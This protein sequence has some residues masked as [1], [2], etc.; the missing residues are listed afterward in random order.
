MGD[1]DSMDLSPQFS[2]ASQL[3]INDEI[4]FLSNQLHV[5]GNISS[6]G[7]RF[8]S[9]A[10]AGNDRRQVIGFAPSISF[11]QVS[12]ALKLQLVLSKIV[13][14]LSCPT[15]LCN[16]AIFCINF[17]SSSDIPLQ[18]IFADGVS[19][20]FQLVSVRATDR[21]RSESRFSVRL[22]KLWPWTPTPSSDIAAVSYRMLSSNFAGY[23]MQSA[24]ITFVSPLN[25]DGGDC[26][27]DF[28]ALLELILYAVS[29]SSLNFTINA[30]QASRCRP[31]WKLG[32]I[33]VDVG[34]G[35]MEHGSKKS[36]QRGESVSCERDVV[37]ATRE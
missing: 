18:E 19:V 8:L 34:Q 20:A 26:A 4:V 15:S 23:T 35:S 9:N 1:H 37:S 3:I 36:C 10:L 14:F 11:N 29:T 28:F 7:G 33:L 5:A 13:T 32:G 12:T 22:R 16:L 31:C 24:N 6:Y 30:I 21:R 2:L 17:L 27:R 25:L